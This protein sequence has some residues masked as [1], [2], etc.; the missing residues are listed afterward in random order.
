MIDH[1]IFIHGGFDQEMPN[2]PT[3]KIL[4]MDLNKIFNTVPA[5]FKGLAYE[6]GK[7]IIIHNPQGANHPHGLSHGNNSMRSSTQSNQRSS[8]SIVEERNIISHQAKRTSEK[9]DIEYPNTA[10]VSKRKPQT[11]NKSIR[12]CSEAIVANYQDQS[13][14]KKVSIDMLPTEHRRLVNP[15][16][17]SSGNLA[18]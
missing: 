4:C 15:I 14:V 13:E 7:D 11:V 8:S 3:D 17:L 12:L 18:H 2:I 6:I 5:L 9:M 10:K 1:N 16:N